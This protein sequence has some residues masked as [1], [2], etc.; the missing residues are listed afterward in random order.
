M[1]FNDFQI[2]FQEVP[3]EVSLCFSISGC[4]LRC[5]GCHS[6]YLW[7]EGYGELL[8]ET[9]YRAFLKKYKSMASC[10][11][12]MGGEW[13][14]TELVTYLKIAIEEGYKTCL[15]TGENNVSDV[16][17]SQLT[18]LKTGKWIQEL[19]GL[20]C[21]K[22]NQKFIEVKTNRNLNHLFIKNKKI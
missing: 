11:L 19:G 8:T 4:K 5:V 21:H 14:E 6:P 15:Y 10:V 16:I 7:K 22:T 18:W 2:V 13:Y 1:C 12:F 17:K 20:N 9:K 3:G